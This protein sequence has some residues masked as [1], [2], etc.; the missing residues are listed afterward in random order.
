MNEA[1]PEAFVFVHIHI[2]QD[3]DE[4]TKMSHHKPPPHQESS[5]CYSDECDSMEY[6]SSGYH[7]LLILLD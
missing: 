1:S 5:D 6:K 7:V 4:L 2:G 3:F